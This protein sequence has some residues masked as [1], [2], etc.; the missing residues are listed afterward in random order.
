MVL[1]VVTVSVQAN[2]TF[3]QEQILNFDLGGLSFEP[4]APA[5]AP[6][7]SDVADLDFSMPGAVVP[8]AA[9]PAAKAEEALDMAFNM[10]FDAPPATAP[11]AAHDKALDGLDLDL[12]SNDFTAEYA[13][14]GKNDLSG[15]GDLASAFDIAP[16]PAPA[17]APQFDMSS[18]DLD[19]PPMDGAGNDNFANTMLMDSGDLSAVHTEMETKLD[20]AIAYQEIGDKE[21]ARELLD[22]VIKGGSSDQVGKANE[23]RAKLA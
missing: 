1:E 9:P 14:S 17:P 5:A 12:A 8:S 19:L 2:D 21:G 11:A 16:A 7:A 15:M 18:I 6:A 22:E 3:V 4:V 13:S 20:L 23:M 10:D